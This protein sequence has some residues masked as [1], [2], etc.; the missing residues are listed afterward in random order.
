MVLLYVN[1]IPNYTHDG[2]DAIVADAAAA[3]PA[4]PPQQGRLSLPP[5]SLASV[6]HTALWV[7]MY[8]GTLRLRGRGKHRER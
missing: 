1:E 6:L 3:A 4:L 5:D 2:D 8:T 7:G